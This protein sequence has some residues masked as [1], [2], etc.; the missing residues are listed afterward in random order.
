MKLEQHNICLWNKALN[1]KDKLVNLLKEQNNLK[2]LSIKYFFINSAED[3]K[4]FCKIIYYKSETDFDL[5]V[6]RCGFNSFINIEIELSCSQEYKQTTRGISLVS[7]EIFFLKNFLRKSLNASDLIHCTDSE[8]ESI[9]LNYQLKHFFKETSKNNYV[10]SDLQDINVVKNFLNRF[11]NYAVLRN[12]ESFYKKNLHADVDILCYSREQI[13]R[14][15]GAKSVTNSRSRV[16]FEVPNIEAPVYL[17]LRQ[18]DDNYYPLKWQ[19]QMLD[20]K[21][22]NKE[23]NI[24]QLSN[25]DQYYSLVYHTLIHKDNIAPDYIEKINF[26]YKKLNKD[27]LDERNFDYHV[28]M[29]RR[30]LKSN[31]ITISPSAD[32]TVGCAPSNIGIFNHFA[33]QNDDSHI[34]PSKNYLFQDRHAKYLISTAIKNNHSFFSKTGN[35]FF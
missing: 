20:N 14:L 2:L 31:K 29:L 23:L 24:Y 5:K 12:P 33:F 35:Y 6:N 22:F 15:L 25:I 1:L 32:Q 19:I 16:L 18:I 7:K 4:K 9:L 28:D 11:A 30:F 17:D 13:I 34:M 27:Q 3:Q 21:I 26:I 8:G 10:F